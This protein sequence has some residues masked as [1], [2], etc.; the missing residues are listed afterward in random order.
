[1]ADGTTHEW[2]VGPRERIKAERT[3]GVKLTDM[4]DGNIGEEYIAYVVYLSLQRQE[5]IGKDVTFDQFLDNH[6]EDY[7]VHSDPKSEAPP[8]P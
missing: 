2:S 5:V 8:A 6:F 4:K 1:M 7:G 3:L